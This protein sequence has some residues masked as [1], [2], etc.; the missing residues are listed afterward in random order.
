MNNIMTMPEGLPQQPTGFMISRSDLDQQQ[1]Q[2]YA[3]EYFKPAQLDRLKFLLGKDRLN[4]DVNEVIMLTNRIGAM[5]KTDETIEMLMNAK[6]SGDD[7]GILQFYDSCFTIDN[8]KEY[9]R[10]RHKYL[11]RTADLSNDMWESLEKDIMYPDMVPAAV[12]NRSDIP[13]NVKKLYSIVGDKKPGN[14]GAPIDKTFADR[15]LDETIFLSSLTL[16]TIQSLAQGLFMTYACRGQPQLRE[17]YEPN[18]DTDDKKRMTSEK[19]RLEANQW[20]NAMDYGDDVKAD[21]TAMSFDPPAFTE[22][23]GGP[24]ADVKDEAKAYAD[25]PRPFQILNPKFTD[26]HDFV[27][28]VHNGPRACP[29]YNEGYKYGGDA[30]THD[31]YLPHNRG[32]AI[33]HLIVNRHNGNWMPQGKNHVLYVSQ[34]RINETMKRIPHI[35]SSC[36]QLAAAYRRSGFHSQIIEMFT[37]LQRSLE[38]KSKQRA[39][40]NV[41]DGFNVTTMNQYRNISML[42]QCGEGLTPQYFSA[43]GDKVIP[44]DE[45]LV[46][47]DG[48]LELASHVSREKIECVP[49][50]SVGQLGGRTAEQNLRFQPVL[51]PPPRQQTGEIYANLPPMPAQGIQYVSGLNIFEG[52]SAMNPWIANK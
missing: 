32:G 39:T 16:N 23:P 20:V 2:L 22:G 27:D 19:K 41:S 3:K 17:Y 36:P 1:I 34:E 13:T 45:A 30:L 29:S 38:A 33:G 21:G 7:S 48:K 42:P 15:A 31:F 9:M 37:N 35:I 40:A 46:T 18:G 26:V 6:G 44:E 5:G 43:D 51:V 10:T 49:R 11:D 12:R 14:G 4:F 25:R 47:R 28:G 8:L 50:V 52:N 24:D